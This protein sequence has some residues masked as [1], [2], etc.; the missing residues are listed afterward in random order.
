MRKD[1]TMSRSKIVL[2]VSSIRATFIWRVTNKS[3]KKR[4]KRIF[5]SL[6]QSSNSS[7]KWLILSFYIELLVFIVKP[8]ISWI[9]SYIIKLN[10][11]SGIECIFFYVFHF[12]KLAEYKFLK[13]NIAQKQ[14]HNYS[15]KSYRLML[16]TVYLCKVCLHNFWQHWPQLFPC[17]LLCNS[18]LHSGSRR[19]VQPAIEC[20]ELHN[21]SFSYLSSFLA[22]VI[23]RHSTWTRTKHP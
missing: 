7:A 17:F 23:N 6:L 9:L 13:K 21:I 8:K 20:G 15:E 5:L 10:T 16:W 12:L 3:G 2:E 19:F 14:L 22:P 18:S 11:K 4:Q 1:Y